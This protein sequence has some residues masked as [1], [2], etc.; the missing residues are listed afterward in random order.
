MYSE[1][2]QNNSGIIDLNVQECQR[3]RVEVQSIPPGTSV[4]K[5]I[6][7]KFIVYPALLRILIAT[8]HGLVQIHLTAIALIFSDL[9]A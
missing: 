1:I 5:T 2:W 3:Y 8:I 9:T 7:S 6:E 4:I